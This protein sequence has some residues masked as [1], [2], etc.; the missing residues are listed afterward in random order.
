MQQKTSDHLATAARN[1]TVAGT[2]TGEPDAMSV[3]NEWA[4]VVAFYSAVH[5]VN[6]ILWER[7]SLEPA[8]HEERSRFVFRIAELRPIAQVYQR[9]SVNA[10]HARY[11]P[12]YRISSRRARRLASTDLSLIES[13]VVTALNRS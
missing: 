5:L 4:V 1:R 3:S 9:L 12:E 2:L 6:A 13:T 10:Y 7:Q 11:T 8:N